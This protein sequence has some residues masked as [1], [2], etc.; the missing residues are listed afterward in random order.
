MINKAAFSLE[1]Y[2]FNKVEIDFDSNSLPELEINF[3]PSG[4]FKR[5]ETESIFEL[6]FIFSAKSKGV[7]KAFV[8]I[9]CNA[10]FKFANNI[11]FEEI[12][13]FFYANSIAII[14][15]YVR[16]FVS[17]VTLQANIL[18]IVLPTMN[19]SSLEKPLREQ[20]KE[21]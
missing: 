2:T 7:S 21:I 19:L 6:K 13:S 3:V 5:T 9:E 10:I 20:T 8:V 17:T 4:M 11:L 14:F 1:K 12:P 16:A 15:P 18:P